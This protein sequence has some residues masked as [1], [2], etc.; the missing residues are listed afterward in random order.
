MSALNE[1]AITRLATASLVDMNTATAST[2]YTVPSDKSCVITSIVVRNANVSLTTASFSFGFTSAVYNDVIANATHTEINSAT[3]YT[4]LNAK[5]GAKLG[6]SGNA[7]K[8]LMNTLQG[9]AATTT[10]EVYGYLF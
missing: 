6:I 10:M 8:V 3:V 9:A 4:I 7:L 1:N 2:L 5:A